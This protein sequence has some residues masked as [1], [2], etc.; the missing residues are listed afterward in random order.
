MGVNGVGGGIE[1]GTASQNLIS[2]T[3]YTKKC[4]SAQIWAIMAVSDLTIVA[5]ETHLDFLYAL[6]DEKYSQIYIKPKAE[7]A[8][9]LLYFWVNQCF[10]FDLCQ[11]MQTKDAETKSKNSRYG[12][13]H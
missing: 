8:L 7:F 2:H 9:A 13:P 3:M 4:S 1:V 5:Y 6:M 12:R 11:F 10:G